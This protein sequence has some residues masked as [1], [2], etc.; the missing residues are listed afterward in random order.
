MTD[1]ISIQI[2]DAN[3]EAVSPE[4]ATSIRNY[5]V[6]R[7]NR[8][9][10]SD[11]EKR[12]IIVMLYYGS[13]AQMLRYGTNIEKIANRFVTEAHRELFKDYEYPKK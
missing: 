12:V 10:V 8:S 13:L 1:I 3:G 4:G 5:A 7:L 11:E 2:L 9:D 6:R